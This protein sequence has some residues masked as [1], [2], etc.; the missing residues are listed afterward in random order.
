MLLLHKVILQWFTLK[1]E[2]SARRDEN[3]T[4]CYFVFRRA[5][6]D[7]RLIKARVNFNLKSF[8]VADFAQLQ[9]KIVVNCFGLW[10]ENS[11]Y[12]DED[13]ISIFCDWY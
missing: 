6:I 8:S 13:L 7:Y 2:A 5:V 9:D 11:K 4:V 10:P 1:V 3:A 12:S